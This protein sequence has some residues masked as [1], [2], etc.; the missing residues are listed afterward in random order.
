[1]P[2]RIYMGTSD[3]ADIC[4]NPDY[5][6]VD[7]SLLVKKFVESEE[8]ATLILRPRRFGKTL[9]LSMLCEFLSNRC[10]LAIG[11]PNLFTGLE[12]S[13]LYPEFC[14]EHQNKYPVILISL[15]ELKTLSVDV[16]L[17]AVNSLIA[18]LFS[19]YTTECQTAIEQL[20]KKGQ[21]TT[22]MHL[23]FMTLVEGK[24]DQ[25]L[26]E[27]SL[28]FL[29]EC[30]ELYY[31]RKVIILIDEYDA[32]LNFVWREYCKAKRLYHESGLEMPRE[33]HVQWKQEIF[34]I[35]TFI[36]HF[37]GAALKDNPHLFKGLMTG[38]YPMTKRDSAS[39]LNN[40]QVYSLLDDE[41]KE[42]FG[43]TDKELSW[44]LT[45]VA[46]QTDPSE[47]KNWY[48]GYQ[49]GADSSFRL[50]NPWSVLTCLSRNKIKAFWEETGNHD[51]IRN[52]VLEER[53]ETFRDAVA[54][55]AQGETVECEIFTAI[56]FEQE[57]RGYES[58]MT[59]L[60]YTG[61][62]TAVRAIDG[63][64][65]TYELR[66]PNHEIR[67]VYVMIIQE[68]FKTKLPPT[69]YEIFLTR[70]LEGDIES[71]AK[72]LNDFFLQ[73]VGAFEFT[74]E[75]YY[76][77]FMTTLFSALKLSHRIY[78]DNLH[79]GYGRPDGLI[80]PLETDYHCGFI[81]E[82]KYPK[83]KPKGDEAIIPELRSQALMGL[84]QVNRQIYHAEARQ[85]P[86]VKT[87][88][89]VG[90]GFYQQR[91][92]IASQTKS[93]TVLPFRLSAIEI[94]YADRPKE[95]LKIATPMAV[96]AAGPAPTFF[97]KT[98]K[99]RAETAADEA[100]AAKRIKHHP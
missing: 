48:N 1:M 16:L 19:F 79:T 84:E 43:F 30:L 20:Q 38:I 96:A 22:K 97:A 24:A 35:H 3:F 69:H 83:V 8:K 68:W 5:L 82:Y 98:R 46:S 32:V 45:A 66:V 61:Y 52:Q 44:L 74:K 95:V 93:F 86:H 7:K 59:T 56:N 41:Y 55:L 91:M 99:R 13:E 77:V 70:L 21:N 37:L 23:D 87:I 11:A 54:K 85:Y 17:G 75:A 92:V 28:K 12:I 33:E 90:M 64:T 60:F 34:A 57:E 2:K 81:L 18:K 50:Y 80:L 39:D 47:L 26:L 73:S 63:M 10:G 27:T 49:C 40:V 72:E 9:N 6:Y 25:K 51:L 53:D 31:G 42:F 62:L 100:Q 67:D 94:Y 15:N 4:S 88:L 89:Q 76:H 58:V 29:S 65:N 36:R 71:F 14:T 78:S